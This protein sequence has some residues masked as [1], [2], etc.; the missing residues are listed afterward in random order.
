M[1]NLKNVNTSVHL[2]AL[3]PRCDDLLARLLGGWR[4]LGKKEP[5]TRGAR[6]G[7]LL[8]ALGKGELNEP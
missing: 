6:E 1:T 5:L 7:G 4:S 2:S 8:E 3:E